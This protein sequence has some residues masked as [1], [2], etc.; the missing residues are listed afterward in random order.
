[1]ANRPSPSPSSDTEVPVPQRLC[2][3]A[4]TDSAVGSTGSPPAILVIATSS[5]DALSRVRAGEALSAPW[6]AA[7]PRRQVTD[8]LVR[9]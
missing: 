8:V 5:D 1:L 4:P 7:T 2:V 9:T 6:L 3:E